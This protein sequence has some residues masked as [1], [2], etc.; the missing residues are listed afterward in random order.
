MRWRSRGCEL[1][2]VERR[3]FLPVLRRRPELCI[4]LLELLCERLRRTDQQVE[5]LLI[6][7][8]ENRLARTLLRLGQEHGLRERGAVRIDLFLSQTELANLAGGTRESVNRHLHNLERLGAIA[9][10]GSTIVIR[11]AEAL[12]QLG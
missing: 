5:D 8:F 4:R 9:L 10:K 11:D 1:L 2:V 6:R 12:E 7:H 3:A